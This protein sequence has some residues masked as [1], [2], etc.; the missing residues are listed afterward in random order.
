L[1]DL[2][3]DGK[4]DRVQ[5]AHLGTWIEIYLIQ[6][7]ILITIQRLLR[8]EGHH[9]GWRK[10]LIE[11]PVAGRTYSAFNRAGR[12]EYIRRLGGCPGEQR[13]DESRRV[14]PIVGGHPCINPL[15]DAVL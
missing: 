5:R 2:L 14:I 7:E 9:R 8:I 11:E 1:D 12:A 13:V 15:G 10:L 6:L 4:V 3:V